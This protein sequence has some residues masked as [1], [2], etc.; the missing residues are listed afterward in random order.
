MSFARANT[1]FIATIIVA[2][3][4]IA[5]NV[6]RIFPKTAPILMP[7]AAPS[8]AVKTPPPNA[9]AMIKTAPDSKKGVVSFPVILR[10]PTIKPI[11]TSNKIQAEVKEAPVIPL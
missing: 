10:K 1:F 11:I 7:I 3:T 2:G 6:A 5:I 8:D 9:L 4:K